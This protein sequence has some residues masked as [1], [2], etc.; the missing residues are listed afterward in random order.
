MNLFRLACFFCWIVMYSAC[1]RKG[2]AE[3]P[4]TPL[5][6]AKTTETSGLNFSNQLKES[7][8]FNIIEYLYFYNGGGV[9]VGDVNGDELPDLF[10][11]ANQ[12]ANKL[13]INRGGLKFGD[14]T[15]QAGI[16]SNDGWSTGVTMAD[17]NGDGALDIYVC[18]VGQYKVLKGKNLLY[19]NN[20]QGQFT[21][22]AAAYGLDFVGFSTQAA[23]FD[24][25]GDGDLDCYLLNHSIHDAEN[26]SQ[27]KI[28][29]TRDP[30]SGDRLYQNQEGKFVD[31]SAKAGIYGS[32]IGFGLG[33]G[34]S[35][36]NLD[37][38]PDLYISND[39]HE[40]DYLYLNQ[41]NG[42]FKEV[43]Q[44]SLGHTSAFSMGNDIADF[45]N[46]LLPDLITL[47]MK[48][49]D[50]QVNKA[51]AGADPYNIYQSK[52]RY[53]YHYQYTRNMLQLNGGLVDPGKPLSGLH[54]A[55][56]GQLAGVDATDW[57]WSPLWADFDN[58]GLKDLFIAN[59]IW[60]R[61]NDL[62]YTKFISDAQVQRSASD[63]ELAAKM[64]SGKVPNVLFQN[65]GSL[66]FKDQSKAW[67]NFQPSCSTGAAYADLDLDGDLD[68]VL[69]NLNQKAELW[70][71]KAPNQN[72][73][74]LSLSDPGSKNPFG[75]GA[76]VFLQKK[77]TK[78]ASQVQEIQSTRGFQSG[79]QAMAHFGLGK[80]AIGDYN[81]V[82]QWPDGQ[83]QSPE[84][85][86]GKQRL[87]VKKANTS[88]Q[89]PF[90]LHPEA[91]G[92]Q[93]VAVP[94]LDYL[95]QES[96]YDD[97][98][99]EQLLPHML[100]T[101]GPA[102]AKGD[103][104]GNG[105]EDLVLGGLDVQLFLQNEKGAFTAKAIPIKKGPD[106]T[107]ATLFDADGDRDL[108]LY[109]GTGGGEFTGLDSMLLD[110]LWLND[111][112]GQFKQAPNALPLMYSN[113][114]F[115][116]PLD[117]DRDG[118]LDLF[119]GSRSIT[120]AYGEVPISYLLKNEK[121][122]FRDVT[123]AEA[124]ALRKLGLLSAG[125]SWQE[126]GVQKMA[127]VGE[128]MPLTLVEFGK[129][130]AT[131]SRVPNSEG[132]W[133]TI[134]GTD[135]NDDG[136]RDFLL[137][138]LGLNSELKASIKEP[139]ELWAADFDKNYRLD[140]I[141]TYYKNGRCYTYASRDELTAQLPGLKKR[142]PEYQA[143]AKS[144]FSEVFPKDQ[145]QGAVHHQAFTFAHALAYG[146]KNGQYQLE[147]LPEAL[148]T[149]PVFAFSTISTNANGEKTFVAVGNLLEV[150]PGLG[151]Y[152]AGKGTILTY[153]KGKWKAKSAL[154]FYVPGA[155]RKLA[156][157]QDGRLLV[158][159][160]QGAVLVFK[161]R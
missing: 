93:Q 142:F 111:G 143:F 64:P 53:G 36:L 122:I 61:P 63:L 116:I 149:A 69:N 12:G 56:I 72:S 106:Y 155:N 147:N 145:L 40:Q 126:N 90:A 14:Y 68:L 158:G 86:A 6:V 65:Q 60:R 21:E 131:V 120:G 50:E 80:S 79:V 97:F 138:N 82:V 153:A 75:L 133:N 96:D 17:V 13:F 110:Q 5:F 152:D 137:G 38:W 70:E 7:E 130:G 55:E 57:S 16:S 30:F 76:K 27:S 81:V 47:D 100:S 92:W 3:G 32:K 141:L 44:S 66:V 71:N 42:S 74:I 43:G 15:Q 52:L 112:L 132:W 107:A 157:L 34:V 1:E 109:L 159:Q 103:V 127:L 160:N 23:F 114:A 151:R 115:S 67:A 87:L 105:T 25:D 121:G 22:Q 2:N 95:H 118:D 39:F 73:L 9:A 144:T 98:N 77:G 102:L 128:W 29:N 48:P 123:Q 146:K 148:Q 19:I 41:Q 78:T 136:Q 45:N 94:G 135:V 150:R 54:F 20:G 139:V 101:Q 85:G 10:F 59:G 161:P 156:F 49:G 113:T 35:D 125:E 28:R 83:W 26:Y 129:K 108:D 11:T 117:F 91:F 99:Y 140:P 51:S 24:Y 84:L 46:D 33:I 62:D 124:P 58:D 154:G 8:D 89:A 4:P 104:D 37:G 31:V 134:Y 18:Q 88:T 119:V